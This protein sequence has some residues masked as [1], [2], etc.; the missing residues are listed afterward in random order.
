[1]S[2]GTGFRRIANLKVRECIRDMPE[3][4]RAGPEGIRDAPEASA[5]ILTT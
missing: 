4:I 3:A 1:V 2:E 5:M